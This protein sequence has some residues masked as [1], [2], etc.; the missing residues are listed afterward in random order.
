MPMGCT[1]IGLRA[2]ENSVPEGYSQPP[3]VIV[4]TTAGGVGC[5]RQFN[6]WDSWE[7]NEW[8]TE[9]KGEKRRGRLRPYSNVD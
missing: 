5:G 3:S 1:T 2:V 8:P 9:Q 4:L 6:L 7:L